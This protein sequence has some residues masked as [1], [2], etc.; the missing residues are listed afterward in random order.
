MSKKIKKPVTLH[1][2]REQFCEVWEKSAGECVRGY[3]VIADGTYYNLLYQNGEF[4]GLVRPN[5]GVIYPFSRNPK[6]KGFHFRNKYIR[7]A[8]VVCLSNAFTFKMKW[9]TGPDDAI[10]LKDENGKT[11]SFGARGILYLYLDPT[12][13]ATSANKFY[14]KLLAQGEASSMD[15]FEIKKVILAAFVNLI[16]KEIEDFM[17]ASQY[18]ISQITSLTPSEK[19]KISGAAFDHLVPVFNNFGLTLDVECKGALMSELFIRPNGN[20]P[21][22]VGGSGPV[23]PEHDIIF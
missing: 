22:P 4:K 16:G 19:L 20:A 17:T 23:F 11:H 13:Y 12:N 8:K 7:N 14:R 1:L 3:R 18:P 21:I 5:G 15:V 10:C 6:R 2:E 9:G